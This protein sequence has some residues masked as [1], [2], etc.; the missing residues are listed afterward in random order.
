M[1]LTM[2]PEC[3][4]T[5]L[6]LPHTAHTAHLDLDLCHRKWEAIAAGK[7]HLLTTSTGSPVKLETNVI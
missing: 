2:C 3:A 5:R 4:V 1:L 7:T 6:L